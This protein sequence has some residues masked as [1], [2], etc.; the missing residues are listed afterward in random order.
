MEGVLA[1][2]ASMPDCR[3]GLLSNTCLATG[4][5]SNNNNLPVMDFSFD[6]TIL[7]FEVGS[8]KPDR[9]RSIKLPKQSANVPVEPNS[10][11]G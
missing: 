11:S 9:R 8:M 2:G 3:V 1:F 10:V 6:A 4:I 7:S 5:G